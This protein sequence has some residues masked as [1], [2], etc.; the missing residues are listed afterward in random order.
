MIHSRQGFQTLD[1]LRSDPTLSNS[2]IRGTRGYLAREWF[3]NI[4]ITAKLWG[5]V[6]GDYLLQEQP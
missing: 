5:H 3:R 4:P 2:V 6:I 1:W